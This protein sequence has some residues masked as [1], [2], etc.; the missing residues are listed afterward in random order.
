MP[1]GLNLPSK[2]MLHSVYSMG[3]GTFIK[4]KPAF[5]T[6]PHTLC[7]TATARKPVT[8]QS[9]TAASSSRSN[10]Q[11]IAVKSAVIPLGQEGLSLGC[12]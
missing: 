6:V 3:F 8:L 12:P 1:E 2:S 9:R 10:R 5:E 11:R 7:N 4:F